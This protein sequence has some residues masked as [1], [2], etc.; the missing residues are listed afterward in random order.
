MDDEVFSASI[1]PSY[2]FQA[3]PQKLTVSE[4]V[5]SRSKAPVL[6]ECTHEG[7]EV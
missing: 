6:V 4:D 2:E 5:E 7:G 1:S 3:L